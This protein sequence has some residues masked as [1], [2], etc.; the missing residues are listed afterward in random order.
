MAKDESLKSVQSDCKGQNNWLVNSKSYLMDSDFTATAH[1]KTTQSDHAWD[2]Y[3][4]DICVD[5]PHPGHDLQHQQE[6]LTEI[7]NAPLDFNTQKITIPSQSKELKSN[8]TCHY[9]NSLLTSVSINYQ[10]DENDKYYKLCPDISITNEISAATNTS[11]CV[12]E[13]SQHIFHQQSQNQSHFREDSRLMTS[14]LLP[15]IDC[16]NVSLPDVDRPFELTKNFKDINMTIEGNVTNST[17]PEPCTIFHNYKAQ[18][19]LQQI[20]SEDENNCEMLTKEK[21]EQSMTKNMIKKC[22]NVLAKHDYGRNMALNTCNADDFSNLDECN[23]SMRS[24]PVLWKF[25][26]NISKSEISDLTN[27]ITGFT[28]TS[29]KTVQLDKINET[30]V[31]DEAKSEISD[32]TNNITGFTHTSLKTVQ[33]DKINETHAEDEERSCSP[34][35]DTIRF[36]IQDP[37]NY[38]LKNRLLA[39]N[40]D[41]LN[42][43]IGLT[44][45][46]VKMPLIKPK[47]FVSLSKLAFFFS[48]LIE[49]CS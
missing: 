17:Q 46:S 12:A 6:D 10:N 30:H 2:F 19:T 3:G 9:D 34:R 20:E 32:L 42:T 23:A 37:F 18:M 21:L 39:R 36:A 14:T 7:I 15:T 22:Y 43:F 49:M 38:E 1:L 11:K 31:E 27:N 24:I 8:E 26:P 28:H 41:T 13:K 29:L 4:M 40:Q 35:D 44:C 5:K 16:N 48:L 45:L 47:G 33:L 25:L